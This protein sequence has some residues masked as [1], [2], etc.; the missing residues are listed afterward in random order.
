MAVST[1]IVSRTS[2]ESK[3]SASCAR[4]I[5]FHLVCGLGLGL[6]VGLGLGL[7]L[8]VGFGLGLGLGMGP[9][10]IGLRVRG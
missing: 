9:E 6:G 7:G 8:G 3:R 1:S 5:A 4:I 10:I 2:H